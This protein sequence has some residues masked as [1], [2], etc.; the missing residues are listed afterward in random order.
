MCLNWMRMAPT[1]RSYDASKDVDA[2]RRI[3]REVGWI[4]ESAQ[5]SEAL[6]V[7]ASC[8][9]GLVAELESQVECAVFTAPGHICFK[10]RDLP[11]AAITAVTT[12][13]VARKQGLAGQLTAQAVAAEALGGAEVCAL[14]M[15]EQG[16][17]DKLGFGTGTY[18]HRVAADP[19]QLVS[20]VDA[21]VPTRIGVQDWQK[22]HNG[23]LARMRGHG[24]VNLSPPEFTRAQMLFC[25]NGFGLGYYSDNVESL[26]HHLWCSADNLELG[27]YCVEWMSYQSFD[28]LL[29][30]IALLRNLG[31]QVRLVRLT[32]PAHIQMQDLISGPFSHDRV[33]EHSGFQ[34]QIT[35][36]ANWQVRICDLPGCLQCTHLDSRE[37]SFNLKLSD[38]I[39]RFLVNGAPWRGAGGDYVVTLGP[40]SRAREGTD[41]ALPCLEASVGAFT[42]LWLGVRPSSSLAATDELRGPEGLLQDLDEVLALPV[43]HVEW[44]F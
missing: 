39:E 42:R 19:A 28:Q 41:T 8:C 20:A 7:F 2:V 29:E 12:G 24:S 37:I 25:K 16:F 14:S 21:H 26:S 15:F 32:E 13:R 35:A 1:I 38:P 30:L 27:P 18:E 9:N 43:P 17:Y 36:A 6:T 33:T 34:T 40:S 5:H 31:D 10:N 3:W 23:R 11:L 22:V 4:D 44:G